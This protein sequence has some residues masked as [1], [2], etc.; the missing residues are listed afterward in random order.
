MSSVFK[1]LGIENLLDLVND[2]LGSIQFVVNMISK[3]TKVVTLLLAPIGDVITAL[4]LPILL[5]IKPIALFM[6]KTMQP[7]M[8]L[9]I[10]ANRSAVEKQAFGDIAGA[11]L[12]FAKGF[13]F[14]RLIY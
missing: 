6:K 8:A 1:S 3:I 10:T 13:G 14:V 11:S 12:D 9:M 5:I 2:I 7:F 4:L